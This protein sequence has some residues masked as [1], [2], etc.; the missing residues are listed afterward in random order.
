MSYG[1][2]KEC[3]IILMDI[4][5][6]DMDGLEATSQIRAM[7]IK[8]PTLTALTANAMAGD[9]ETYLKAGMDNYLSKPMKI[10]SLKEMIGKMAGPTN[11]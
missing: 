1:K 4:Q 3:N 9:R 10:D 8:Q 2:K 6:P 5:M 7:Q 11:C